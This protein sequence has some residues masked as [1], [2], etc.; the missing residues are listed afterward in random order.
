[1][2]HAAMAQP[3]AVKARTGEGEHVEGEIKAKTALDCRPQELEHASCTRPEVEQSAQALSGKR[4][5]DC[6]LDGLL[7]HM[8]I[9][10]AVPFGGVTAEIVL[11]C[12]GA[13]RPHQRQPL[14]VARK[15]GVRRIKP[16]NEIP[17]KL[18]PA[19]LLA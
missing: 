8:K 3:R 1:M 5:D 6:L 12:G 11:R 19:I 18:G 16:C 7:G 15:R 10:N 17:R 2:P 9:A 4:R 13:L 14:T